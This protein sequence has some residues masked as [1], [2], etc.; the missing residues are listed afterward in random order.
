M[1]SESLRPIL[2]ALRERL[3]LEHRARA[4]DE[5]RPLARA[6]ERDVLRLAQHELLAAPDRGN[7]PQVIAPWTEHFDAEI[8]R[9]ELVLR[10]SEVWR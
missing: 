1:P 3:H 7:R 10:G 6:G 5:Q 2:H 9:E 8:G 4:D